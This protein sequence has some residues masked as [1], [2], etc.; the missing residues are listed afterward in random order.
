MNFVKIEKRN[1]YAVVTLDRGKVN[2]LNHEMVQEI[3][4]AFEVLKVDAEVRGVIITGKPHYFSAGLDLIELYEYDRAEISAFWVDLM[5]MMVDLTK[6]E[7]P[8]IG[9]IS[10]HSP[11]GGAVIAVTCDHRLMAK[12]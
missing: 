9:A 4:S 11:A 1:D 10:G 12:S 6:F 8:L 3:R 7:K 2:A 5:G